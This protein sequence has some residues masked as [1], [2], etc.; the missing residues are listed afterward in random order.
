[1]SAASWRPAAFLTYAILLAVSCQVIAPGMKVPATIGFVLA[2]LIFI[3]G[4]SAEWGLIPRPAAVPQ[5]AVRPPHPPRWLRVAFLVVS[6]I[7]LA[8]AYRALAENVFTVR[9]VVFWLGGLLCFLLGVWERPGNTTGV[10]QEDGSPASAGGVNW[11]LVALIGV[12]LL[13]VFFR[14][15]NLPFTPIEMTSDHAEKLYDVNDV[16]NGKRPIFFPRNTGREAL[17]FYATAV[18]IRFTP[19]EISH[20][21]LKVGTGLFGVMAIPFTFLLGRELY[22]RQVGLLAAALMAVGHWHVAITR[23]GLRFPFTAAFATPVLYFLFRAFRLNQRRDWILVGAFLGIGL[24]TYI[25]MRIVPLLLVVLCLVKLGFDLVSSRR[26]DGLRPT[27]LRAAFWVNAVIGALTSFILFLPLFRYMMDDPEM[28]WMRAASRATPTDMSTSQMLGVF[29]ENVRDAAMMFNFWGDVVAVNTIGGSPVLGWVT[30]GLFILGLWYLGWTM[31]RTGDRRPV[32]LVIMLF[33]LLLP[34]T[35]SIQFP[36]ENPSVVR[37]GGA[38]PVVMIIAALPLVI[39]AAAVRRAGAKM[40]GV[41]RGLALVGLAL[42][43]GAATVYNYHWYFIRYHDQILGAIWNSRDLGAVIRQWRAAGGDPR[44]AYQI[45]YP[46]WVDTRLIG[47]HAGDISW[48]NDLWQPERLANRRAPHEAKLFLLHVEDR[49]HLDTL[50]RLFPTGRWEIDPSSVP[51]RGKEFVI[52]EV[53]AEPQ[54]TGVSPRYLLVSPDRWV[55]PDDPPA[56]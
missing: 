54:K 23:V 49:E 40:G 22:N 11:H 27:S 34:S 7:L 46:H 1:M 3:M 55:R 53:P 19:L 38:P 8:V 35:L 9:G 48:H 2:G 33:M 25:P 16:L 52:F 45:G 42:V 6:V 26:S 17:Q 43:L 20:L 56:G 37:T 28:F 32:Y 12:I 47:I 29:L 4:L 10:T 13:A 15:H 36:I 41:G 44:H 24:H 31:V 30:G 5:D 21:A 51:G 14:F 39:W 50:R 18:L